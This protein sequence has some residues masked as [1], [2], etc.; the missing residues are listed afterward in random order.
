VWAL[1][2][3]PEVFGQLADKAGAI[4]NRSEIHAGIKAVER[5]GGLK[6]PPEL[7]ERHRAALRG[8]TAE[9]ARKYETERAIRAHGRDLKAGEGALR[10]LA[11]N[12]RQVPDRDASIVSAME[13]RQEA[14]GAATGPVSSPGA[15][16]C[17][18]EPEGPPATRGGA[19]KAVDQVADQIRQARE[20]F[21]K[22][23][24]LQK[25]GRDGRDRS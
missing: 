6:G 18:R 23:A 5:E 10:R 7:S 3:R 21:E 22:M 8:R 14:P 17:A 19:D 16:W 2:K 11:E 4:I 25:T 13:G 24:A 15:G 20:R 1:E 9:E 12:Y